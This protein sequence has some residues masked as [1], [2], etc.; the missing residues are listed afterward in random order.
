MIKSLGIKI[1][2]LLVLLTLTFST[3]AQADGGPSFRL[4]LQDTTT[5]K[6]R[7]ITD[8]ASWGTILNKVNLDSNA[9]VGAIQ[10]AGAV[11]NFF[12]TIDATS[13]EGADGGGILTL[14][15]NVAFQSTGTDQF[16]VVLEDVYGGDT[17][18]AN[19]TLE[20]RIAGYNY[21]SNTVTPTAVLSSSSSLSVQS[22]LD[23]TGVVPQLGANSGQV[24]ATTSLG[25]IPTSGAYNNNLA[26]TNTTSGSFDLG[27]TSPTGLALTP[28]QSCT[29]STPP[30]TSIYSESIL[31]FTNASSG[32]SASF[33]LTAD[34]IQTPSPS[35]PEPTSLVL[36]GSALLG[37]GV[38]PSRKKILNIL[39]PRAVD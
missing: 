36:L 16:A 39:R 19:A 33:T 32:G 13:S 14:S 15:A 1:G 9:A 35:V 29:P 34:E 25:S 24:A 23:A 7:V 28:G 2:V 20:N 38:L 30:C 12:V 4:L 26:P 5:G 37:L 18:G 21:V 6:Q 8:N 10:F 27:V 11:G 3:V 31:Q 17:N 22:W